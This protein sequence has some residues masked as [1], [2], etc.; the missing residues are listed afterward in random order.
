LV[1][2]RNETDFNAQLGS[3]LSY[4]WRSLLAGRDVL[5]KGLRWQSGDGNN[6]DVWADHGLSLWRTD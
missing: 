1:F 6:V 2:L 5:K 4:G 3:S